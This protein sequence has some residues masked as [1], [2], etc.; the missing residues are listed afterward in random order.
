[1]AKEKQINLRIS[2]QEKKLLEQDAQKEARS[3][4]NFLLWCWKQWRNNNRQRR[5]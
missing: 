3:I 4:S 5:K 2:E 1:M